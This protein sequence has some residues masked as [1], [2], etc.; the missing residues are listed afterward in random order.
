MGLQL[1]SELELQLYC[2]YFRC[3]GPQNGNL[4][5]TR[6]SSAKP[7]ELYAYSS[8]W[9]KPHWFSKSSV[10]R[11]SIW[12]WSQELGCLMR[13]QTTCSSGVISMLIFDSIQLWVTLLGLG[14]LVRPCLS[15]SYLTPCSAFIFCCRA[16]IQQILRSFSEW[17][18]P[19]EAV[20]FLCL[21]EDVFFSG[22]FYTDILNCPSLTEMLKKKMWIKCYLSRQQMEEKTFDVRSVPMCP[23]HNMMHRC[24]SGIAMK[25]ENANLKESYWVPNPC[26]C[27]IVNTQDSLQW[28]AW[29]PDSIIV[30]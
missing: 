26:Q 17:V 11:I 6:A 7:Q 8:H 29:I 12:C 21:W 20:D 14:Y 30:F 19:Y 1:C 23:A 15:L 4:P 5:T 25:L 27:H 2:E 16:A 28:V 22:S 13:T 9:H 18:V 10:L 3:T 24:L